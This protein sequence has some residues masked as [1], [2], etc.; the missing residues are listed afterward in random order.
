MA[1]Y[2][3]MIDGERRGPFD[4]DAL[5]EAGVGPDTY[6][7]TKGMSDWEHARDVADICRYYRQRIFDKMHPTPVPVAEPEPE[8][9]PEQQQAVGFGYPFPMP[10][11][12]ADYATEPP[13]SLLAVSI[14][15][16]LLCFPPTGFVAIYYAVMS[17]KAW[18]HTV[19]SE[20]KSSKELYTPEERKK[21]RRTAYDAARNAKMWAGITFFLGFILYAFLMNFM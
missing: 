19:K 20:S 1:V 12:E 21:Y 6:V 3:A 11:D 18:D 14:I 15:L 2:F 13:M 5:A 10:P 8:P 16:T 7:W 9:E 17:R 4:L